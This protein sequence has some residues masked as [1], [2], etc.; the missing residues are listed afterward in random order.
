MRY[1]AEQ[2]R[3]LLKQLDRRKASELESE[4]L[5]MCASSVASATAKYANCWES[6]HLWRPER[7][8]SW[9]MQVNSSE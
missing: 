5:A 1:T 8:R 4:T 7:S 3:E 9:S 2:I 6:M